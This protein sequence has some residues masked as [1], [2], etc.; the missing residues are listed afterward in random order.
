MDYA[1]GK[2]DEMSHQNCRMD[3]REVKE[4]VKKYPFLGNMI[5]GSS[6]YVTRID[7][8][9]RSELKNQQTGCAI[10]YDSGYE[11]I[12][13]LCDMDGFLVESFTI[14]DTRNT[15]HIEEDLQITIYT[16][17]DKTLESF[18]KLDSL[19][20]NKYPF[21][22]KIL[23]LEEMPS[24]DTVLFLEGTINAELL[25][26]KTHPTGRNASD[27][28]SS[29]RL[30]SLDPAMQDREG[31]VP[32]YS[33]RKGEVIKLGLE[34]QLVDKEYIEEGY[35]GEGRLKLNPHSI[36][37]DLAI[38]G[39]ENPDYIVIRERREGILKFQIYKRAEGESAL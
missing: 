34:F 17:S 22:Q 9:P 10:S 20:M 16:D 28:L 24:G 26:R 33:V 18:C 37:E 21:M 29:Y 1:A 31:A 25:E 30:I 14:R 11:Y 15:K 19:G 6:A 32:T 7:V 5:T 2:A 13:N 12:S 4:L 35:V 27:G 38:R 3:R 8:K 36:G 39:I 23:S